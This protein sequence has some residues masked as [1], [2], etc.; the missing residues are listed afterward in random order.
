MELLRFAWEGLHFL[1]P[2]VSQ[3]PPQPQEPRLA[4][5]WLPHAFHMAPKCFPSGFPKCC[6]GSRA[7]VIRLIGLAVL[8]DVEKWFQ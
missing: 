4:P 1:T 8:C 2:D 5:K 6:L 7:G 3:I